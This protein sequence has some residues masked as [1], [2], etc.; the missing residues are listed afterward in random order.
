[1]FR[2][3]AIEPA[4]LPSWEAVR[5]FL[6]NVGPWRGRFIAQYPKHWKRMVYEALTCADIARARVEAYLAAL[7]PRVFSPRPGAPYDGERT[8]LANALAE[9]ARVPFDEI[10]AVRP[11]HRRR[12]GGGG[13]RHRGPSGLAARPGQT[14]RARPGD[15]RGRADEAAR[16]HRGAVAII[17]PYFRG[18]QRDKRAPLAAFMSRT[19]RVTATVE[20]HA[21]PPDIADQSLPAGRAAAPA[22]GALPLGRAVTLHTWQQR[23]GGP[24]L[25]NRYLIT[26]VG[27]VQF[28]DGVEAGAAGETDR[29]SILEEATRAELWE[30]YVAPGT[31]FDRVGVAI[32]VT[33]TGPG[34]RR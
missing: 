4:A 12:G 34:R 19:C 16:G 32:T 24:R 5:F 13:H 14:G 27:G 7:D 20:I 30:H 21:S 26:D 2:E 18:D 9:H 25:H 22:H 29:V 1:M 15:V 3:Y 11:R 6:S 33:G 17:D 10:I 8:W 28:G 23:P 31:A